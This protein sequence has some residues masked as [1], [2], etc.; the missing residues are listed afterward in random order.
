MIAVLR[1]FTKPSKRKVAGGNSQ[2]VGVFTLPTVIANPLVFMCSRI[3]PIFLSMSVWLLD[4]KPS[5]KAFGAASPKRNG[6]SNMAKDI[7]TAVEVGG[8]S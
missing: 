3:W 2:A 8:S 4:T 1:P 5:M 6:F 7:T